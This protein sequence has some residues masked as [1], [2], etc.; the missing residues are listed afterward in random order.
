MEPIIYFRVRWFLESRPILP[1]IQSSRCVSYI[2]NLA[3]LTTNISFINNSPTVTVFL[4]IVGAFDNVIPHISIN[5]LKIGIPA[6]IRKFVENLISTR[7]LNFVV[8]SS[9]FGSLDFFKGTQGFTLSPSSILKG[10]QF[11]SIQNPVYCNMQTSYILLNAKLK[12]LLLLF[13]TQLTVSSPIL[14]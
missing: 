9:F 1:Q 14:E 4:D 6:P 11:P 8:N 12:R 2:D 3:T 5:L 10:H 13:R 7:Y